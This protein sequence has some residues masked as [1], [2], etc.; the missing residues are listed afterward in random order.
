M[1]DDRIPIPTSLDG[2]ANTQL[3]ANGS[4]GHRIWLEMLRLGLSMALLVAW[5]YDGDDLCLV[6]SDVVVAV[7]MKGSREVEMMFE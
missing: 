6:L 7:Y 5:Y 2:L 4:G 1:L 3:M